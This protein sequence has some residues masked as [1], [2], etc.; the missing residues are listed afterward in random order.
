[1][2]VN[3]KKVLPKISI[4]IPS[5]NQGQYIE[6]AILSI[7]KQDYHNCEIIIIDGGSTD[8]TINILRKYDQKITFWCSEPDNGQ[9]HAINKGFAKATG[10][11]IGW[12]NSDDYYLPGYLTKVAHAFVTNKNLDFVY[13]NSITLDERDGKFYLEYGK[14]LKDS[15]L[16]FGSVIFSHTAFW[17]K[18]IHQDLDENINCAM[19][20]ELWMRLLK[21]RN[22][23]HLNYF[24]GVFRLHTESKSINS[25]NKL[26]EKW[27]NDYSYINQKYDIA[28][29]KIL[30]A[31][32][33]IFINI[34]YSFFCSLQYKNKNQSFFAALLKWVN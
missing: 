25:L 14:Y 32:I 26:K 29:N 20:Y 17:K 4:V 30:L 7:I 22:Y 11:I 34:F 16:I 21:N 12:I 27:D 3:R 5:Y 13:A 23:K 10:D 24:G 19:D 31:R 2:K 6:E 18:E 1:M 15:F 28:S 33:Y 8:E 9:A